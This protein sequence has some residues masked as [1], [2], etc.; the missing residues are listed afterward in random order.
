MNRILKSFKSEYEI[1][2]SKFI[3][4]MIPL[5]NK[6]DVKEIIKDIQKEYPKATHYCYAYVFDGSSKSNDDG[7]PSQT[8]GRPILEVILKNN[9][10][11]VLIVVV[12]YFGGIKLGAG[13]LTR[14]YVQGATSVIGVSELYHDE[15]RKIYQLIVDYNQVDVLNL[16]LRKNNFDI[17]DINYDE[18]VI[19][20][21][22]VESLNNQDILD[23]LHGKIEIEY[24]EEKEI[25][26]K[27]Q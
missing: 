23:Y 4:L 10:N 17:V 20:Q 1:S 8:A 22:S 5:E 26:V 19:Y 13:G 25:L 7:E 9:L 14:A 12:R 18:K 21:V 27:D 24:I 2:R 16:Y 15:V 11:R 3:S 6:D